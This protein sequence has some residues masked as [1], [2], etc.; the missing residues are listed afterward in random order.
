MV[1]QEPGAWM[2]KSFAE[3]CPDFD[4]WPRRWMGSFEDI[5][6]GKKLI[7]IF[8]PFVEDLVKS[9]YAEKTIRRHI[10][11]LWLL[12]GEIVRKVNFD[13]SLRSSDTLALLRESI[14][15]DGG[16]YCR[17]LDTEAEMV[18]FDATC[19]KLFRFLK[20]RGELTK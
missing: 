1:D 17:H 18:S 8:R 16:P 7:E 11:N 4:E 12:G 14:G 10:D 20:R 5:P 9:K 6:F 2:S 13:P 3:V 19:R 15:F